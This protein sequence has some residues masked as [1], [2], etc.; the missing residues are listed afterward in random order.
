V[1]EVGHA[2][3]F[4]PRSALVGHTLK[5]GS[6]SEKALTI[7]IIEVNRMII[8]SKLERGI[9]KIYNRIINGVIDFYFP[10]RL[11]VLSI[12]DSDDWYELI[13]FTE[14]TLKKEPRCT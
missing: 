2:V 10:T 11:D 7:I 6:N 14:E 1:Q 9:R 12:Y 5:F 8:F 3:V 4:V 13:R